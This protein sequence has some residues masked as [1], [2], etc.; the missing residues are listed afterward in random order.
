MAERQRKNQTDPR[1]LWQKTIG[2]GTMRLRNDYRVKRNEK[3][4]AYNEDIP[5]DGFRYLTKLEPGADEEIEDK[6]AQD[7][8]DEAITGDRFY[9][10]H[11]GGPW[12]D[13]K[14]PSGQ[15]M[16]DKALKVDEAEKLKTELN[17]EG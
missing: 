11:R 2:G 14:S 9:V 12:Y 8:L 7:I 5:R 4:R 3:F 13:V 6:K 17:N 10:D 15:V 1:P 16:N